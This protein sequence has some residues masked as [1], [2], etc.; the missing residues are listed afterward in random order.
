MCLFC[1][2]VENKISA[3]KIYEDEE[4][5]AFL[6]IFPRAFGHT[7]VIP[8]KH[9]EKY[10]DMTEEDASKLG[11]AIHKVANQIINKL[12]VPAYNIFNNN[13]KI[14]G[15]EIMHVHFHILPRSVNDGVNF[16]LPPVMQEAKDKLEE[17]HNSIIK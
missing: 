1:Q 3:Y 5:M 12:N 14:S 17:I 6:D 13:G 10:S 4:C 7:L 16:L 15:Q 11:K 2:I 8:K 9:Y